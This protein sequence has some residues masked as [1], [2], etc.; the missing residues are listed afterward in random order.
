MDAA[1]TVNKP[2]YKMRAW[3]RVGCLVPMMMIVLLVHLLTSPVPSVLDNMKLHED[4]TSSRVKSQIISK[5]HAA[6]RS[7]YAKKALLFDPLSGIVSKSKGGKKKL[8]PEEKAGIAA[9]MLALRKKI[10]GDFSSMTKFGKR[11]D[12][13]Y[14][15]PAASCRCA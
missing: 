15:Y 8:T 13:S 3:H 7:H 12:C 9:R 14:P 5:F 11:A 10:M 2:G 4:V 6:E 1:L